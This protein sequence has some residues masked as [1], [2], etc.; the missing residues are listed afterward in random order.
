MPSATA[1][2]PP[3]HDALDN[4]TVDDLSDDPFASP[5]PPSSAKRKEPSSSGLGIDEEV[6]V[7]KRARVPNVKLDEERLLGPAGI[8]KLRERAGSLK[9]KGKGHEFSDTARLLSFYQL[10]LDDLFPKARFLDALAMVEKAGHK[11]QVMV[12]RDGWIKEGSQKSHVHDDDNEDD[13]D[14]GKTLPLMDEKE[15]TG[16]VEGSG[17]RPG[18]QPARPQTPQS[19]T[20]VPDA[21]DLYGV[22]PRRPPARE[23]AFD[24]DDVDALQ[25]EAEGW[26]NPQAQARRPRPPPST[27]EDEDDLDALIAEAEGQDVRQNVHPSGDGSGG[28]ESGYDFDEE[29]AAMHELEGA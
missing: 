24:E 9:I 16:A 22:T 27:N 12:A 25:A 5:S 2:A 26:G 15:G 28:K 19:D 1:S 4:Y 29:E 14:G 11:K 21:D 13:D 17:S 10:W 7:K 3:R 8:P 20:E 23:N 6:S 18:E